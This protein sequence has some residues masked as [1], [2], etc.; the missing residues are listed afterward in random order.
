MSTTNNTAP[1][2]VIF[3]EILWDVLPT[4]AKPGGAPMNVAYHLHKLGQKPALISRIG[5]DDYGRDLLEFLKSHGL[6]ISHVQLDGTH[7][8]GIVPA[9]PNEHGEMQYDIVKNVAWDHIGRKQEDIAMVKQAGHF[10]FGSLAARSRRSK[11]TLFQLLENANT[12]VLDINLRPPHYNK[13]II[14]ELLEKADII[15]MNQAELEMITG[16]Y[17]D[18]KNVEER[19]AVIQDRFHIETLIVTLGGDG[20]VLNVNG[21]VYK[22]PGFKVELADTVGAGDS[23]LAAIISQIIDKADP[24]KALEFASAL[25][26]LVASKTGGCPA[27]EIKDIVEMVHPTALASA[28]Q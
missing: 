7:G 20:A 11:N 14:S 9:A 3:G 18:F 19:M 27:Y 2:V 12:K 15:K 23:F 10:V 25:G 22:H 24:A 5:L 17:S 26:G 6:D 8:T 28:K 13:R 16:W 1:N 4:G 21:H